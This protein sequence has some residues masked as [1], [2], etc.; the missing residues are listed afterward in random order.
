MAILFYFLLL[1]K[2]LNESTFSLWLCI[3]LRLYTSS[4]SFR[5]LTIN[6]HQF[7]FPT[8]FNMHF[9]PDDQCQHFLSSLKLV[10]SSDLFLCVLSIWR[11]HHIFKRKLFDFV[12]ALCI[13]LEWNLSYRRIEFPIWH[14]YEWR[15]Q[16][17]LDESKLKMSPS[18][19]NLKYWI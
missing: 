10:W 19:D 16:I 14:K 17:I 9:N 11:A 1:A 15:I 12:S 7:F 2:S 18:L 5:W 6:S 8:Y 13:H 3:G 4:D